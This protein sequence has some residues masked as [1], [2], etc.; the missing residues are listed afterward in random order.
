MRRREGK[1]IKYEVR[2]AYAVKKKNIY[3]GRKDGE[4]ERYECREVGKAEEEEE[5]GKRRRRRRR[6]GGKR[7]EFS[8]NTF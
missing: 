6:K 7:D 8:S 5:G 4:N 3:I 2:G 1:E